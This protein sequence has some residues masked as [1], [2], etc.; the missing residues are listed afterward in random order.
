MK[1][2]NPI[3]LRIIMSGNLFCKHVVGRILTPH[4]CILAIYNDKTTEIFISIPKT[5]YLK[6]PRTT[7]HTY[8]YM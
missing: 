1:E 2:T 5:R 3:G 6:A 4:M 7:F 8:T